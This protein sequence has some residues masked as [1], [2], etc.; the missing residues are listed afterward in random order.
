MIY[1]RGSVDM[2]VGAVVPLV[3]GIDVPLAVPSDVKKSRRV[4][5]H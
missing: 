2:R 1:A 3:Q 4:K 5:A